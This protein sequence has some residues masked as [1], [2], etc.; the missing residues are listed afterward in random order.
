MAD[1]RNY[2]IT[3]L[4]AT[5]I[6]CWWLV[7]RRC[8]AASTHSV[9]STGEHDDDKIFDWLYENDND[10]N[11]GVPHRDEDGLTP[12]PVRDDAVHTVEMAVFFKKLNSLR[13]ERFERRKSTERRRRPFRPVPR[14]FSYGNQ[15]SKQGR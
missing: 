3:V 6:V 2:R 5:T 7:G 10:G 8:Y 14:T 13:R 11:E 15:K 4:C 1:D 9:R 12:P